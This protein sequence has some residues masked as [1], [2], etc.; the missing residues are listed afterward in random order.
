MRHLDAATIIDL[1]EQRV[2]ASERELHQQHLT[3]C[4]HCAEEYEFWWTFLS[5]LGPSRLMD[6]P[7]DLVSE[8]IR[9]FPKSKPSSGSYKQARI[10]FDNFLQPLPAMGL[11]GASSDSRHIVIRVDELDVH[12][13]ISGKASS[14]TI[15]G[16]L[17][18]LGSDKLIDGALIRLCIPGQPNQFT[19]ANMLGE[20]R[21][22]GVPDGSLHF[23]INLI[24][25]GQ[26]AQFSIKED[27]DA[28]HS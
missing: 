20:F 27:S 10:L 18:L 9:M 5:G 16:Q 21:F 17:L 12:L 22:D 19:Y 3:E 28:I 13:R 25:Q 23:L 8:C 6:A 4:Q 15:Q 24:S 2:P 26:I 1:V 11:R 14:R 7:N